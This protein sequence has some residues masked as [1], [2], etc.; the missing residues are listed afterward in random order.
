MTSNQEEKCHAIIHS[1]AAAAAAG[2]LIP[3]PGLDLAADMTTLT[4][5]AFA[6]A[7]VFG[8]NITGAVA[9]NLVIGALKKQAMKAIF[10]SG[11]KVV[12]ILGQMIGAAVSVSMLEAAG[13]VM[14]KELDAKY[15]K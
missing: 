15:N 11:L 10:K 14:A 5:M 8:A 9:Q 12:P 4:T 1:H 3:V 7:A 13:W 6:L 2:N